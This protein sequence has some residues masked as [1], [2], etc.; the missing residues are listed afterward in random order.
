LKSKAIYL[1]VLWVFCFFLSSYCLTIKGYP[2]FADEKLM[3][4]TAVNLVEYGTPDTDF[5]SLIT[6]KGRHGF[7][8][9]NFGLGQSLY[10]I[11]FYLT[12]KLFHPK[13]KTQRQFIETT[14][15]A[16]SAPVLMSLIALFTLLLSRILNYSWR[17]SWRNAL[18]LG[19]CSMCWPYSKMLFRDPLQTLLLL[20]CITCAIKARSSKPG[21]TLFFSGVALGFGF[22]VKETMVVYFPFLLG[23][24]LWT[25]KENRLKSAVNFSIPCFVGGISCLCYNYYRFSDFWDF[26]YTSVNYKYGMSTPFIEGIYGLLISTGRGFFI[27]NPITVLAIGGIVLLLKRHRKESILFI[28]I[29][30]ITVLF[31]AKFWSWGGSWAWGPRF[32]LV[33]TPYMAVMSGMYIDK[34]KGKKRIIITGLIIISIIVQIPGVIMHIAPYL[35]LVANDVHLFPLTQE[36]D[37]RIRSD[38]IHVD[39]IPQFSPIWGLSWTLKHAL[40]MPFKDRFQIRKAMQ[41]D[42][43][44]SNI[45]P[46]WVPEFPDK[47]LGAGPD[48]LLL[49]WKNSYPASFPFAVGFFLLD[50]LFALFCLVKIRKCIIRLDQAET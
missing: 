5:H 4:R 17:H 14:A 18:L 11:P 28:S 38:L 9:S 23:Y 39:F 47:A 37:T 50:A 15:V 30:I 49:M 35:S 33:I 25:Q 16:F 22:I 40:S 19:F 46:D 1:L 42:C 12:S 3:Y 6:K 31:Y 2:L 44:W 41:E 48:L 20:I 10:E 36:K 34:A 32:L 43:P 21:L 13:S 8:Y 24:I 27:F 45:S 7:N 29:I 26:C